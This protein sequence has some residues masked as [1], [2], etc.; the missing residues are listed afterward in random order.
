MGDRLCQD[1]LLQPLRAYAIPHLP[2]SSLA[3]LRSSCRAAVDLVDLETEPS[4]LAAAAQL[5]PKGSLSSLPQPVSTRV[6]QLQL[7]EEAAFE[8][9]MREGGGTC[10]DDQ[11]LRCLSECLCRRQGCQA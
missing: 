5:L 4:W 3:A 6:V 1:G 8:A 7:R 2:A 11:K 9:Q 10:G